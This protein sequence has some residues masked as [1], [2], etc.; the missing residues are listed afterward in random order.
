MSDPNP[1]EAQL[2]NLSDDYIRE[3]EPENQ[4]YDITLA[5]DFVISVLPNGIKTWAFIYDFQ[6]RHRRKTLGVFPEMNFDDA[7]VALEKARASMLR[8]DEPTVAPNEF[9]Q[10]PA[11]LGGSKYTAKRSKR[12][13]NFR[14]WLKVLGGLAAVVLAGIGG[15]KA[16]EWREQQ[17]AEQASEPARAAL[18]FAIEKKSD[19][20]PK[21]ADS[22]LNKPKPAAL[23]EPAPKPQPQSRPETTSRTSPPP[24]S[25]RTTASRPASNADTT[26]NGSAQTQ[27]TQSTPTP[28][29]AQ[30]TT[31]PAT[32]AAQ[33]SSTPAAQTSSTPASSSSPV[34][35]ATTTSGATAVGGS[36]ARSQLTSRVQDLEP[37]DT[38]GPEI[39]YKNS[40]YTRVFYFTE[41]REFS[42]GNVV[43]RWS[44]NGAIQEE[45][46]LKVKKSW[47]WR[48]Y[49]NKDITPGLNGEWKVET[50]DATGK[51]L[52]TETFTY[53][54]Q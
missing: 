30:P 42:D 16:L 38:L 45:V 18:P 53:D 26:G 28:P 32:T 25:S 37:T 7:K 23:P 35:T 52:D 33:T 12:A 5:Q 47:R 46:E 44:L 14:V 17:A 15:M 11:V 24:S 3:L 54:Y 31:A 34:A 6:G 4:R 2:T 40:G 8:M 50:I 21:P 13:F 36:V 43:H 41:L 22:T 19:P 10:L 1:E 39:S 48:T 20:T 9:G 29:P 51:I 27:A 49:S